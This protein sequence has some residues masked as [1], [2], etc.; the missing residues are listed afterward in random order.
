M[1]PPHHSAVSKYV[2]RICI[3]PPSIGGATPCGRKASGRSA[4]LNMTN[5]P[6]EY[7]IPNTGQ[8]SSPDRG[9][10]NEVEVAAMLSDR[11]PA[12]PSA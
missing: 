9:M 11:V 10:F 4:D 8:Q 2:S 12:D 3:L 6:T 7:R 5:P 1:R